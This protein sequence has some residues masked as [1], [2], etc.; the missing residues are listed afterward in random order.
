MCLSDALWRLRFAIN[1]AV[2]GVGFRPFVYRLAIEMCLAGWVNNGAAGVVIEVEGSREQLERFRTRLEHEHPPVARLTSVTSTWLTPL[3]F[4]GFTITHSDAGGPKSVQVLPDLATCPQCRAELLDPTDRRFRYPF[5]NCTNCG[6][7]FTIVVA[8]PYDRPNTTM[9]DFALCPHCRA[10]YEQPLDRRFHAQPNACPVCGP[11][12]ELTATGELSAVPLQG[13]AALQAAIQALRGGQIVAVKGLGG[14]HLICDARDETVVARLRSRKGRPR[15]PFAL[16]VRDLAMAATLC[17]LP[18][19]AADLLSA[20][21]AP[22]VLLQQHAPSTGSVAA[23]VAPD[24]PTLGLMLP[25][26][27]LHTLL[28]EALDYP[29]VATSGNRSDEPICLEADEVQARLGDI[30]DLVL[31]HNRPIARHADD[32][33]AVILHGEPRLWRR[34]RGYAPAPVL[35]RHAM[36]CILGLGA[37]MKNTVAL[38]VGHQVLLSQHIGDLDAIESQ[39]AFARVV[40]D[41]TR[42]YEATPVAIAHDM[43]PDYYTTAF[44]KEFSHTNAVQG[45]PIQHHHAHFAACLAEHQ[46]EGEAL[47]IIWDG[48]GFGLDKTIWGG[49]CLYGTVAASRRVASLRSIPLLGMEAAIREPRRV[50]LALLAA[51]DEPALWDDETLPPVRAFTANERRVLRHMHTKQ[52]NT[53][54][55]SSAGRLFDGVAA[56]RGLCQVASFEGEAA[57]LLEH[58][59]DPYERGA[60]PLV[61][62]GEVLDWCPTIAALLADLRRGISVAVISARFHTSLVTALVAAVRQF[63]PPMVVLSGGC[64][65]NRLLTER[66]A[67][68]LEATGMR[69]LLPRLVPPNDGGISL[70]QVATVAAQLRG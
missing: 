24:N 66:T 50:A 13:E 23:N 54:A 58:A 7:R 46:A 65:Q 51:L 22:I 29:L 52:L 59:A 25:S 17:D 20:P 32:S 53:I 49:E 1:G 42:L 12:L 47:G 67:T 57:S 39:A 19:T 37:Q 30:A 64:F 31:S 43:H 56:L 40:A 16:L 10:E 69:V 41:L 62:A 6:P 9:A 33:I 70:G 5:I 18:Q 14:F 63:D 3:G 28:L 68:A 36:P 4:Q 21:E 38:S 48:T 44:A 26:T 8:L 2:Q 55:T 45:W 61:V 35:L 27:P 34:A 15:K 11:H 60:Y